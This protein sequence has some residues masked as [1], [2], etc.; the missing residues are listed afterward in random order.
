VGK[1]VATPKPRVDL[2][3]RQYPE[4]AAHSWIRG[5]D[6]AAIT[7]FFSPSNIKFLETAN[8]PG[9][10]ASNAKSLVYFEDGMLRTEQDFD[11]FI[12]RAESIVANLL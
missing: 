3:P 2:D 7:E 8:L 1:L 10:L 6:T 11:S 9:V 5:S 4:F 12:G